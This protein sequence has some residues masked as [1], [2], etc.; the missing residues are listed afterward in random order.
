MNRANDRTGYPIAFL[1]G[2]L[3]L[4]LSLGVALPTFAQTPNDRLVVVG[5]VFGLNYSGNGVRFVDARTGDELYPIMINNVWGHMNRRGNV[6][7]FPQYE[8]TDYSYE[9][10]ARA[11]YQGKTGFL[12]KIGNWSIKPK[13]PYADRFAE[14]RAVVGNNEK[15]RKFGYID[16]SDRLFVPMK[17]D[18]ALRFKDKLAGVQV[19]DKCGFINV[20]GRVQ[21]KLQFARVRSFHEN[22]AMVQTLDRRGKPGPLGYVAG[23]RSG[24]RGHTRAWGAP[25]SRRRA[26]GS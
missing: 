2:L 9:K 4:V 20:A 17:L 21:I 19:G 14:S 1:A 15:P 6:V 18:G 16:K 23:S 12:D 24:S 13:Y 11:V 5:R 8:W 25:L 26:P 22:L 10:I 3:M 7:I